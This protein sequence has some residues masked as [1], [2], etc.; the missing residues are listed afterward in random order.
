MNEPGIHIAEK[1]KNPALEDLQLVTLSKSDFDKSLQRQVVGIGKE[2]AS[3]NMQELFT[4]FGW[5]EKSKSLPSHRN[6]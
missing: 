1:F 6:W 2:S 5:T 3:M 4:S